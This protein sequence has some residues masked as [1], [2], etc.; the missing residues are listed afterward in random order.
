MKAL[1]YFIFVVILDLLVIGLIYVK[2]EQWKAVEEA[3]KAKAI[4][5]VAQID[6]KTGLPID[7]KTRLIMGE[8]YGVIKVECVKCHPTQI[9]R[10][11]H[12]DRKGW[13]DA[14]RWMQKEKGLKAFDASD[15]ETI[16]SYL[17]TYYGK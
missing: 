7:P 14:I 5:P 4:Q 17:T 1:V 3:A 16:L 8:G 10:S 15:E 6:S 12:A 2:A 9:V 13:T 11:F